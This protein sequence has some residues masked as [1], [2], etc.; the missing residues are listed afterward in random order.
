MLKSLI[1]AMFC[2][3]FILLGTKAQNFTADDPKLIIDLYQRCNVLLTSS[4]KALDSLLVYGDLSKKAIDYVSIR[5]FEV[6]K[7]TAVDS[8]IEMNGLMYDISTKSNRNDK[9]LAFA[10]Y[11]LRKA[12]IIYEFS[13]KRVFIT[14]F[15]ALLDTK[16]EKELEYELN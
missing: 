6:Q 4:E 16:K 3:P 9:L 14:Y 12:N 2:A 7:S 13:A 5:R 8:A 11:K 1:I 15:K 10:E